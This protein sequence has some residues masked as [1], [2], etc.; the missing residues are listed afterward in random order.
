MAISCLQ[1]ATGI[2]AT[3]QGAEPTSGATIACALG[4]NVVAGSLI[5]VA[6]EYNDAIQGRTVT[7]AGNGNTFTQIGTYMRQAVNNN[8]ALACF[9]AFNAAAGATTVT[10]TISAAE[11]WRRITAS[12]YSGVLATSDPLDQQSAKAAFASAT[13]TDGTK[14]NSITPTVNNCLIWAAL[15]DG[16]NASTEAPGTGFTE[17]AR[18]LPT[19]SGTNGLLETEDLLQVAAAAVQA[20]WTIGAA[21]EICHALVASFKPAVAGGTPTNAFQ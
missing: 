3:D 18:V 10:A 6:V 5:V 9:Y 21:G 16:T 7:V 20:T 14:S 8:Q 4:N 15:S 2:D 1:T 12:E 13:G 17:R 11:S 19:L